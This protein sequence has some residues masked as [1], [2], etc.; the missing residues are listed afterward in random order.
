MFADTDFILA[1][2][3]DSDW[4]KDKAAKLLK[5]YEGKIGTS[6]SVMI[7]VALICKR[8]KISAIEVFSNVFELVNIKEESYEICMRAAL[9]IEKYELNVF[10][11]FHAAYC[12]NDKII[13]SDSAYEKVGIERIKLEK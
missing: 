2:V 7:E 6:M 13:S 8:L 10:D 4:L 9:Y 12:G 11:A 3:K 5:G 1:L